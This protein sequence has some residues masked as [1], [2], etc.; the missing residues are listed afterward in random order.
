MLILTQIALTA[1][2]K[3]KIK[4]KDFLNGRRNQLDIQRQLLLQ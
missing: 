2:R 4:L 3:K 1:A